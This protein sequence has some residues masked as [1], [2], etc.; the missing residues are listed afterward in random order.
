MYMSEFGRGQR[1]EV[2][3]LI[4]MRGSLGEGCGVSCVGFGVLEVRSA[5]EGEKW[6]GREGIWR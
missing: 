4:M 3:H 5:G 6:W 1:P 2:P